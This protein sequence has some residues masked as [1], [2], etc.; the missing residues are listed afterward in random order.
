[1]WVL[2]WVECHCCGGGGFDGGHLVGVCGLCSSVNVSVL[3][4][5]G[6]VL[7]DA[8]VLCGRIRCLQ[9][10]DSPVQEQG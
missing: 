8:L 2:Q 3:V 7:V 9:Q 1:M 5:V 10:V 6:D 4:G